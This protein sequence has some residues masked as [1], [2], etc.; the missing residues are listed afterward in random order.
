MLRSSSL[1]ICMSLCTASVNAAVYRCEDASGVPHFTD[2]PCDTATQSLRKLPDSDASSEQQ[3]RDEKTRKLLRAYQDERH[4]ERE[5]QQQQAALEAE[6]KQRCMEARDYL[7]A[8]EMAGSLYRLDADG[9]RAVLSDAEREL[10]V[11]KAR[12][13]VQRW[14]GE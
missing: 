3:E 1:V 13:E 4:I 14:C 11:D 5:R 7:Q 2:Q 8:L 12:L 9:A 10:E 6:R